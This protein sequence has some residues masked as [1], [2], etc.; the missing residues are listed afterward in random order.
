MP[1]F[2]L[3]A[4][5]SPTAD[6]PQGD[7]RHRRGR[8]VRRPRRDAARRHRHRQDD[9]DG[10]DDRAPAAARARPRPQQDARGPAL[11]RVPHVLPAERRRVLRLLLRLLPARGLRPVEGP[12]HREGLGDQP[13]DRPAAP[14][15]HRGAVR[16]ARRRDRRVGVG[17]LRP[18]LAGDLQRQLPDPAQGRRR[19]PRRAA[20]QARLPPVQP[21]RHRARPRH[22]PR[23]GRH[24]GGLPRLRRDRVPRAAVRRRGRAP[25]ALRPADGRADRRRPRARRDLAGHALQRQG[26]ARWSARSRRSAAS[27]THRTAELEAE[28]KLLESHRLRQRTQYDMEMLREV[29]FCSGI[30]NYSRILDGRRAG[31]APVLPDR[32]LPAATSSASSTSRTRRCRSSARCT[33]ATAR[34]R[35]RWSTTA[36]G[37]RARS[38]TGRRRS[39]SSSRSRRSS[40]SCRRRPARTSASTRRRSSSRSCGRPGSST[41][42]SRSARRATRSTT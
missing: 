41:P 4:V 36:S 1:P 3:D 35:R 5:Y 13:G 6:Q 9:D 39:R 40:C 32:L 34:A 16:A 22:V 8:R 11:Q 19:R 25:A 10:R 18:R 21:Q 15:R 33:R 30:E 12:L 31:R 37:S 27:S 7:R 28:G 38:T 2:K 42:R 29:G 23:A 26:R 17:D 14:R 24:A 20:A